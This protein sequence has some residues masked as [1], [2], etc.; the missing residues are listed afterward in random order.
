MRQ[1]TVYYRDIPA[2]VLVKDESGYTFR[3]DH[4]YF[5]DPSMPAVSATLP[6]TQ[7]AKARYLALFQ[8]RLRAIGM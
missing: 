1:G 5:V 7:E 4:S 2:G 3:Y 6:K 8:D